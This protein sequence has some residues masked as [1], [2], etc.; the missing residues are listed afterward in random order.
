VW[1]LPEFRRFGIAYCIYWYFGST[2]ICDLAVLGCDAVSMGL[3]TFG[4]VLFPCS[5]ISRN[6]G[7]H[8][9]SAS[10][11]TSLYLRQRY[12]ENDKSLIASRYCRRAFRFNVV[13]RNVVRRSVR[14]N[15][16]KRLRAEGGGAEPEAIYI[17][18][19]G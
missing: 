16:V 17:V 15:E 9:G 12:C 2:G 5:T 6:V 18:I 3:E 7:T 8:N 4:V 1:W 13:M 11:L 14:E 10:H 19:W